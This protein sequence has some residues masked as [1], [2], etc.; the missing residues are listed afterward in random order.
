MPDTFQRII[1]FDLE[2]LYGNVRYKQK[3]TNRTATKKIY[4]IFVIKKIYIKIIKKQINRK[5]LIKNNF[6]FFF[7]FATQDFPSDVVLFS[8]KKN[9]R[10]CRN[11]TKSKRNFYSK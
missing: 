11:S 2:K 9:F 10:H 4:M 1:I 5:Y 8:S 7:N 6:V 3:R